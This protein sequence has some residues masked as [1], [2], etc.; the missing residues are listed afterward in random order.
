MGVCGCTYPKAFAN[1]VAPER[2]YL[3]VDASCHKVWMCV[4]LPNAFADQVYPKCVTYELIRVALW[5]CVCVCVGA[6]IP[7]LLQT[8]WPRK[9]LLT[10]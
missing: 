5:V 7:K 6:Q 2:C 8:K 1:Q 4:Q 9:V 10:S 3:R